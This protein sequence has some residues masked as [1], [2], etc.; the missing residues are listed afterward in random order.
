MLL[1]LPSSK[2]LADS[3]SLRGRSSSIDD[4]PDAEVERRDTTGLEERQWRQQVTGVTA[5]PLFHVHELSV[6]D[7]LPEE[8]ADEGCRGAAA[9]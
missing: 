7:G 5:R 3:A 8:L 2:K 9:G 1:S 6:A 4:R